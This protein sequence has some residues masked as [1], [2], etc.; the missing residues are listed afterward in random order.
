MKNIIIYS[1]LAILVLG[2]II[3]YQKRGAVDMEVS[4]EDSLITNMENIEGL[5]IEDLVVG[6][7]KEVLNGNAVSVHYT[8]WLL[9]GTKF[10]SSVD[11]GQPFAFLIGEGSVIAGWDK[12]LLGMKVGGKRILIIAPEL[13][14]GSVDKGIIPPNSTLKFEIE[15]LDT[16]TLAELEAMQKAQDEAKQ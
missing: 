15:L 2:G 7:G 14:Y 10:D 3:F 5:Q 11:R 13:G 12:G 6:E 1:I 8:G 16:A 4:E 9:D